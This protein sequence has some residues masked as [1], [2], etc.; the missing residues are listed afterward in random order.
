MHQLTLPSFSR[1]KTILQLC[2]MSMIIAACGGGSDPPANLT[3]MVSMD[4][5]PL[6]NAGASCTKT[7]PKIGQV[8][9]LSTRGHGVSGQARVIDDCTIE[10]TNFNFDGGGLPDVFVYGAKGAAYSTGFAI[11]G[12]LFGKPQT[13]S[14]ILLTLKDKEIDNLDGI[15]IWCVRASVS[16][17]DGIFK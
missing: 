10:L 13:N 2:A 12:N 17:G 8:A 6:P 15:S 14:T 1:S 11:G 7:S 5:A 4:A 16:F 9:T 3:P